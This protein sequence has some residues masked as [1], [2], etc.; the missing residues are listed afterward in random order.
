MAGDMISLDNLKFNALFSLLYEIDLEFA[1]QTKV[2]HCPFAGGPLHYANYPRKPRGGHPDLPEAFQVR[3][4]LCC[5]RPEC[6]RRVLPPSVRF[7]ERK[8]YWAPG[9]LTQKRSV[10]YDGA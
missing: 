8:V 4:S 2:K 5:S 10:L 9:S 7:Y 1:E 6:R 3:F